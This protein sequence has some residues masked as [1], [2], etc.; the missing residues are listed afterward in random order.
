MEKL[1]ALVVYEPDMHSSMMLAE[2]FVP[3]DPF[4]DVCIA[5]GS[6]SAEN[7]DVNSSVEAAACALGDISSTIAQLENIVCRVLYLPGPLDPPELLQR[8]C[9]LTPNSAQVHGRTAQLAPG[10]HVAG[11]T[12]TT[13]APSSSSVSSS[14]SSYEEI[15]SRQSKFVGSLFNGVKDGFDKLDTGNPNRSETNRNGN[16]KSNGECFDIE[17]VNSQSDVD[18]QTEVLRHMLNSFPE[19]E[20][21]VF[22]FHHQQ[23][24]TLCDL[25]GVTEKTTKEGENGLLN[26]RSGGL[27]VLILPREIINKYN[28]LGDEQIDVPDKIHDVN[29]IQPMSLKNGGHYAILDLRLDRETGKWHTSVEY[30][31]L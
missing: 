31:V 26:G 1:T 17:N 19:G 20:T 6:F 28:K 14:Q 11:Y 12:E 10:L 13:I 30:H 7:I 25:I 27:G 2:K 9:S 21:T 29:I 5:C 23:R 4:F 15:A 24:K 22:V 3:N 16:D 8:Q 18:G